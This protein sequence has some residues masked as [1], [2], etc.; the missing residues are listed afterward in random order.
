MP[1]SLTLSRYLGR[2]F[3]ASFAVVF[4]GVMT[5]AFFADLIELV[6]RASRIEGMDFSLLIAMSALKLPHLSEQTLPFACLFGAMWSFSR[7]TRTQEL[8]VVRASGVSVWQFM[9]PA[10]VL[11]LAIGLFAVTVYNP[12]AATMVARYQALEA[13]HLRGRPSMLAVSNSGFWLRQADEAGGQEVIHAL[14][15]SQQGTE[16]YD[17]IIFRF[18]QGDR[19]AG[20]IDARMAVLADG[21]WDVT[22]AWNTTLDNP[23]TFQER[24]RVPTRLT[25]QDIQ[26][27]FAAPETLS[28]WA[29]PK[30]IRVLETAGFSGIRHRMHFHALLASPLLL[31][32]MV[33]IAASVSLRMTRRGGVMQLIGIGMAAGF[34]LYIG[35]ELAQALGLAGSVP[36]PLAAWAPAAAASLMGLATLFHLEDG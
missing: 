34:V 27:S 22:D 14:R 25:A 24:M 29:L 3:L 33:L 4:L 19:F 6:R 17:V 1:L 23:A 36:A 16:L 2:H 30:F 5:I 21:Y 35:S 9:L 11:S 13:K 15:V 12:V 7:L 20:R 10:I 32:A 18:G 28:F 31:C 26:E 8:A